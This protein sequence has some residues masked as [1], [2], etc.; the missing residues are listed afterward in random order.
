MKK[1]IFILLIVINFELFASS[2]NYSLTPGPILTDT[3]DLNT[4]NIYDIYQINT[5]NNSIQLSW[6]LI[7]T[8]IPTGWD[9]SLCEYGT[10]YPGIPNGGTMDSIVVGSMGF[11]G[12]NINPYFIA[13]TAMVKVYVYETGFFSLGD[14]LTW[15]I[16]A[17]PTSI[18]EIEL[19][20]KIICYPNPTS[21][22]ISIDLGSLKNPEKCSYEIYDPVGI[23]AKKGIDWNSVEYIDVSALSSG[24]YFLT[25]FVSGK[26]LRPVSFIKTEQE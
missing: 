17:L 6:Q 11:L 7:S 26:R 25:L 12:L 9:Y 4:L 15:I 16:H 2:P 23:L 24:T 21:D 13:G 20:S 3:A 5:S 10:C 22:V 14:T 18:H 1:I 19:Q 8:S